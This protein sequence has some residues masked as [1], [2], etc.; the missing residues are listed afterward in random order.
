MSGS[1]PQVGA[2]P[3]LAGDGATGSARRSGVLAGAR[4]RIAAVVVTTAA[5]TTVMVTLAAT[6]DHVEFPMA[7]ALYYGYLVAASALVGLYWAVRRPASRF[8]LL[9]GAFALTVWVVS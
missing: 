1:C 5:M 7:A 4:F 9:L 8:G 3:G 6:S 2:V